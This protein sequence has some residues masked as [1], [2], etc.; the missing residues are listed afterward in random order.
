MRLRVFSPWTFQG[1]TFNVGDT[2]PDNLY[3]AV[4]EDPNWRKYCVQFS[5]PEAPQ[6]P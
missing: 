2:I 6:L 5:D 4:L 3:S 1:Q